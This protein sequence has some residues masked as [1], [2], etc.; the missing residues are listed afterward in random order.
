MPGVSRVEP[1]VK[2]IAIFTLLVAGAAR[3]DVDGDEI[4]D[5]PLA[6]D[7]RAA[8]GRGLS[9]CHGDKCELELTAVECTTRGTATTCVAGKRKASGVNA[10]RL[11]D[12]LR[13]MASYEDGASPQTKASTVRIARIQCRSYKLESQAR[14]RG[15][16]S[17][18]RRP[19]D[20]DFD[21]ILTGL[22]TGDGN[23]LLETCKLGQFCWTGA[24]HVTCKSDECALT[25]P[26]GSEGAQWLDACH[27]AP[28]QV[29]PV[30]D[31]AFAK[32]V[33]ARTGAATGRIS[34]FSSGGTID[35][36]VTSMVACDVQPDKR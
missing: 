19:G 26:A 8:F 11:A 21:G 17:V 32:Q 33:H 22:K 24:V 30:T 20:A 6:S 12:H 28:D 16:C 3:A 5:H 18:E 27:L 2:R 29:V 9:S 31:A 1:A 14:L 7:L 13:E 23:P 4:D 35:G 15:H 25:C 34:C 36:G 10:A